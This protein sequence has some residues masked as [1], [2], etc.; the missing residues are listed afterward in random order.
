MILCGSSM[1]FMFYSEKYSWNFIVSMIFTDIRYLI[2]TLWT[3]EFISVS[4]KGTWISV[5]RVLL[6]IYLQNP[7]FQKLKKYKY[8]GNLFLMTQ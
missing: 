8:E 3:I 4:L 5:A 1:F 6:H 2:Q 7:N